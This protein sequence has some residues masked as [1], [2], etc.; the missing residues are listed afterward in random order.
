MR[1][2]SWLVTSAARLQLSTPPPF[3]GC[4]NAETGLSRVA[5]AVGSRDS[6]VGGTAVLKPLAGEPRPEDAPLPLR[7]SSGLSLLLGYT[8]SPFS[9]SSDMVLVKLILLRLVDVDPASR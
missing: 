2:F 5:G 9:F 3:V 4:G 6:Y 1:A 7:R 8:S